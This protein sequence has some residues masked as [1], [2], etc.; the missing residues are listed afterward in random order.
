M[1]L[2]KNS[3]VCII[4]HHNEYLQANCL[5]LNLLAFSGQDALRVSLLGLAES[6]TARTHVESIGVDQTVL[7]ERRGVPLG[8]SNGVDVKDIHRVN[9][10]EG[11][12]L[13]LN[14]EEVN[15]EE[16]DDK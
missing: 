9:L 14:H 6:A 2:I 12:S 5:H 11:A 4:A 8:A 10:F 13:R 15:D 1:Q 3:T 7:L 16:E